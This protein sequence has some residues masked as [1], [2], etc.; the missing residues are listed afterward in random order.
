[1]AGGESMATTAK[2]GISVSLADTPLAWM[3]MSSAPRELYLSEL[4]G[5]LSYALDLT[6]GLPPGHC[7]RACWLGMTIGYRLDLSERELSDL[8]YTILLKDAGCSSNAARIFEIYAN[9]DREIKQKYATLDSQSFTRVARFVL[10][11]L[12]PDASLREK[13][14]RFINLSLNGERLQTELVQGRCERGSE[15]A[16]QMG[17]SEA[18]A[19]GIACLGEHWN[20]KGRPAHMSGTA[21]PLVSRIALLAQVADVFYDVGGAAEAIRQLHDRCATWFDPVLVK[22]AIELS[23]EWNFF[24]ALDDPNLDMRVRSLEPS[25]HACLVDDTRMDEIAAAFA[26]VIDSKSPYTF[27]HSARVARYTV[28]I[29]RAMGFSHQQRRWL[30]RTALLHDI[31]KLAVSN[32]ILDKP[33]KLTTQEWLKVKEHPAFSEE[34]L[35]RIPIFSGLAFIAGSH[36]ERLDGKGYPRGLVGAEIPLEA[37]ILTVADIFDA[38]TAERPYHKAVPVAQ[39]LAIMEKDVGIAIDAECLAALKDAISQGLD[40]ST[41][42]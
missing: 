27:G 38:I 40:C 15:I 25:T 28:A 1:M 18:V 32:A 34:I 24:G 22:A 33:G 5:A 23:G 6:E 21:I 4:I 31:G 37:R 10:A 36:H 3:N 14:G 30:H 41:A 26:R 12:A 39:T 42:A 16:R 35:K 8:Y 9:D 13:I 2:G 19:E 17:F 20:G 7:L 29:A 11:N